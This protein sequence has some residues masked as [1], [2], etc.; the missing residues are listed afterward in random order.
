V[1]FR[2]VPKSVTLNDLERRNGVILRSFSEFWYLPGALRKSSRSLSHLLMS[3][4]L[5]MAQPRGMLCR[6]IC[7]VFLILL[8]SGTD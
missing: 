8:F 4:C 5:T 1:S 2:L 3:S 6:R 7:V